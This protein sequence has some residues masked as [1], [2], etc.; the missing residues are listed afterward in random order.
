L[1]TDERK[2]D[3]FT[4]RIE[5]AEI[6]EQANEGLKENIKQNIL[7]FN[8]LKKSL[9]GNFG[10]LKKY[11][12]INEIGAMQETMKDLEDEMQ[13]ISKLFENINRMLQEA[14]AESKEKD[15]GASPGSAVEWTESAT[16]DSVGGKPE[17]SAR[18]QAYF[19]TKNNADFVAVGFEKLGGENAKNA[20]KIYEDAKYYYD[21]KNSLMTFESLDNIRNLLYIKFD[22]LKNIGNLE[23]VG[24]L[25]NNLS[26]VEL[27]SFELQVLIK[28][29][30]N[31]IVSVFD[32]NA[33]DCV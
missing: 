16:E 21:R 3:N 29:F 32:N 28:S 23:L 22:G 13:D 33:N 30:I 25:G 24:L 5:Q 11:G 15:K 14:E 31:F 26:P 8:R 1:D 9:E 17:N 27:K 10:K 18:Y 7:H 12:T 2:L 19:K 4:E 6:P 20:A